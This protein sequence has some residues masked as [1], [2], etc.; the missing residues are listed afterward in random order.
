MAFFFAIQTPPGQATREKLWRKYK[1][2]EM[3]CKMEQVAGSKWKVAD[4]M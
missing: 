1:G 2:S 3:E 4:G